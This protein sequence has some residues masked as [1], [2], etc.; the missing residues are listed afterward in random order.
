MDIFLSRN[1][2]DKYVYWAFLKEISYRD[3]KGDGLRYAYFYNLYIYPY[4]LISVGISTVEL[5]KKQLCNV[6]TTK[7]HCHGEYD[8]QK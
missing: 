3:I 5:H 1:K 2:N 7:R 6:I 8:V 4:I